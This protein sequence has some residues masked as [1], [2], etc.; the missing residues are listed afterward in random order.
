VRDHGSPLV[1]NPARLQGCRARAGRAR[2]L[3]ATPQTFTR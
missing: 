2:L 1:D 3:T